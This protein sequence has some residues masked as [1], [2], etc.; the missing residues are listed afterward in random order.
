MRLILFVIAFLV[1]DLAAF[2][3]ILMLLTFSPGGDTLQSLL[4]VLSPPLGTRLSAS[5]ALVF[6]GG[7]L[8]LLLFVAFLLFTYLPLCGAFRLGHS[9]CISIPVSLVLLSLLR[10]DS[11][12]CRYVLRFWHRC[13][14]HDIFSF[15]CADL[16]L[17]FLRRCK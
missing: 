10:P 13:V 12:C 14:T 17:L 4:D 8:A 6:V 5:I 15:F 2:L 1:G 7:A 3:Y 9:F 16:L 11:L